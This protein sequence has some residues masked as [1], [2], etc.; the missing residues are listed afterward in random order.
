VKNLGEKIYILDTCTSTNDIAKIMAEKGEREGT[1]VWALEQI[2]G[3]GREGRKW[4]SSKNKGLYFSII[5]RPQIAN[6]NLLTLFGALS[7]LEIIEE[8]FKLEVKLKWPND[9]IYKGK[10]LGGIL[11]EGTY[12]GSKL[13]HIILGIGV[14]T[15]YEIEDFPEGLK[16]KTTSLRI[17]LNKEIENQKLLITILEKIKALY[18]MDFIQNELISHVNR[19]SFLKKGEKIK[20]KTTQSLVEGEYEGMD[21]DGS[22][23]LNTKK[24]KIKIYSGHFIE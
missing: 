4:I 13:S 19:Y 20:L 1:V 17:I 8:N 16:E 9:L 7:V 14:N 15:N 21:K 18:N 24:G 3:R 11:G 5:L 10:K 2:R 22:L 6:P 23:L 12:K